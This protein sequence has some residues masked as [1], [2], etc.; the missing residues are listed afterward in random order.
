MKP[1]ILR[2]MTQSRSTV[3]SRGS[4]AQFER[5]VSQLPDETRA[6]LAKGELQAADAAFYVSWLINRK[7]NPEFQPVNWKGFMKSLHRPNHKKGLV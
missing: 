6:R 7:T 5:R 3:P 2:P 1:Q 4:R